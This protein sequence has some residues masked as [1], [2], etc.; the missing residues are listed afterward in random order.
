MLGERGAERIAGGEP[1]ARQLALDLVA[2]V[3]ADRDVFHLWRD[4]AGAGIGE[5][6]HR[7]P[8]LGAQ[9]CAPAAVEYGHVAVFAAP[10]AVILGFD[11]AARG[12]LDIAAR[13]DP[14]AAQFSE[15]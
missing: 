3:F 6:G 14:R 12:L 11:L 2:E 10:E 1:L 15:A 13:E 7:F 8:R 9:H 4:D 5:L